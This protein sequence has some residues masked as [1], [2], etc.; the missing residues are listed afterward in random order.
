MPID[1]A[2][3]SL[4]IPLS[5]ASIVSIIGTIQQ[6]KCSSI[7]LCCGGLSCIRQVGNTSDVIESTP[8]RELD[9][10]N[11]VIETT[12]IPDTDGL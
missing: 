12:P 2:A 1:I 4:L 10:I 11:D 7:S 8:I 3:L 6:S 9:T 5:S